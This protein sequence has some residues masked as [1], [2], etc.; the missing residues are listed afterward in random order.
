MLVNLIRKVSLGLVVTAVFFSVMQLSSC[1][2]EDIVNPDPEIDTVTTYVR[3]FEYQERR[4]FD[5]FRSGESEPGDSIM[6]L[7]LYTEIGQ[8]PPRPVDAVYAIIYVNPEYPDSFIVER[9]DFSSAA[10]GVQ[11]IDPEEFEYYTIPAE[12]R[13]YVVF[14]DLWRR[15]SIGAYM[16]IAR[17]D[18]STDTIGTMADGSLGN[19]VVLKQVFNAYATPSFQTWPLMWR[20]AYRIPV[21]VS[22]DDLDIAVCRGVMGAEMDPASLSYQ[23]DGSTE[24]PYLEVLG[25]DQYNIPGE[26]LPDGLIDERVEIF[27]SDWGL[28]LFPDRRPFDS[29]TTFRHDDFTVTPPLAER[30]PGI[31]DY[32]SE[33]ERVLASE[34]F[35]KLTT[36]IPQGDI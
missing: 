19:P 11:P 32:G 10:E 5:L 2:D 18:G 26:R 21:G 29:D 4:I 8:I 25:L 15:Y 23:V 24:T 31:Y 3:D 17:Q 33:N 12:N 14:R 30:V 20:N 34:Y 1:D 16:V 35:L 7:F 6:Q 36:Y 13:H 9:T 27:R 28:L 22:I